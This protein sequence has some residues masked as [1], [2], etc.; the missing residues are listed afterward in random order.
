M[1]RSALLFAILLCCSIAS[2]SDTPKRP[3]ILG[4]AG[5]RIATPRDA[6]FYAKQLGFNLE[7][8][9]CGG[10]CFARLGVNS[11]QRIELVDREPTDPRNLKPLGSYLR[12]ILFETS[13]IEALHR[14]L[15]SRG[16]DT[17]NIF[18]FDPDG[19]NPQFGLDDPEGHP[20]AFMQFKGPNQ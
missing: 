5:V 12:Q 15:E 20:I 14:Y 10:A 1:K 13:D 19:A 11:H 18:S 3:P 6:G 17:G 7:G 2:T 16:V 4:I 8:E 9:T